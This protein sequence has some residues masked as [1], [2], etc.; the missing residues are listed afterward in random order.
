MTCFLYLNIYL[1]Q[2]TELREM[3]ILSLPV[4]YDEGY[5]QQNR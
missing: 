1:E 5:G 2:L 3:L 4:L